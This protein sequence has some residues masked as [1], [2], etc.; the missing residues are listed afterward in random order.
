M[1]SGHL[2]YLNRPAPRV[3]DAGPPLYS[4]LA[5]S[6]PSSMI[7]KT[8]VRRQART[9]RAGIGALLL[10][11][12]AACTGT[13]KPFV[14]PGLVARTERTTLVFVPGI[15]GSVL[16]D[17]ASGKVLWGT[18][19]RLLVPKDHGWSLAVPIGGDGSG[20]GE[21]AAGTVEATAVLE[22]IR[23]G[24]ITKPIYGPVFTLLEK[25][26]YRRGDLD[27]PAAGDNL[28]V[29][30]YDWRLDN[31]DNARRLF[32]KLE[33]LRRARGVARLEVDLV[34][35]SNGSHICRYL[36]KY[37]DAPL[38]DAA[39][40]RARAPERLAVG[41]LVFI[42]TANGGS[43]RILREMDR[44]R[45]YVPLAGRRLEP[46]T[47]FTMPSLY[48]ELPAFGDDLFVD[49]DGVA[50]DVDLYDAASWKRYGWSIFGPASARR[51][52]R[53]PRP[54]LFATPAAREAFLGRMLAR[55]RALQAALVRDVPGFG[56]TRY[57]LIQNDR[58][59]TPRRAVLA[60]DGDRW[61]TLFVG[62]DALD[63]NDAA[64][65]ATTAPG[66]GHA[67]VDSQAWLSPQERAAI[68]RPPVS[69]DGPHFEMILRSEAHR[70]LL[71]FLADSPR[72]E[73]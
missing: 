43:M 24:P 50:L 1:L 70:H 41:K 73:R 48:Q 33:A 38:E 64:S 40:G 62:D 21:G 25:N 58:I 69:V 68:A 28:F 29:F 65:R 36:T 53:D 60:R 44:G 16:R 9:L 13:P 31:V 18:G 20:G 57:Y 3:A 52:A 2:S 34:C 46:E 19:K 22:K 23:L 67:T 49:R 10:A 5:P 71:G 54:D 27:T 63:G 35:Q 26:G 11:T 14:D 39:A 15:T 4:A 72:D 66:D 7:A 8:D 56:A 32:A 51:L 45:R 30:A 61:R 37:G 17:R 12:L 47:L 6:M 59:P 42:G 55:A